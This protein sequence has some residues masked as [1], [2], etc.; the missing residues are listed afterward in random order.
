M[1]SPRPPDGETQLFL[2]L[3]DLQKELYIE[4]LRF[5]QRDVG[6]ALE[7]FA[8]M[9]K[10]LKCVKKHI[11]IIENEITCFEKYQTKLDAKRSNRAAS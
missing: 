3:C 8:L 4:Q 7:E 10:R 9:R 1:D 5:I 6:D 2:R 11:S